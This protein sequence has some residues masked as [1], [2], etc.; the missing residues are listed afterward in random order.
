MELDQK[1]KILDKKSKEEAWVEDDTWR[2]LREEHRRQL[3]EARLK[4]AVTP[5]PRTMW[6]AKEVARWCDQQ[7]RASLVGAAVSG[8]E[9]EQNF[10]HN[11]LEA[12]EIED[13]GP[14]GLMLYALITD[15]L[16]LQG[17]ASV[18]RLNL[19][20]PP[21]HYYDYFVKLEWEVAVSRIG[22]EVYRRAEELIGVASK[23]DDGKA[24]QSITKHRMLAG[25]FK[26]REFCSEERPIDGKWPLETKTKKSCDRDRE[27]ASA[28][29]ALRDKLKELV[30]HRL[31]DW[32][33]EYK[34]YWS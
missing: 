25:T 28:A 8:D 27:L 5:A 32:E 20:K 13:L 7:L 30:Q 23:R 10:V 3:A 9:L 24:P 21:L 11:V 34:E 1:R 29:E 22:G 17:D 18:V 6:E 2:G 12:S 31:L 26:I 16:K 33:A 15:V 14:S 19:Q 4:D